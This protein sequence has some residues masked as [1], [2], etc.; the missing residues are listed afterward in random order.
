MTL[1]EAIIKAGNVRNSI[2]NHSRLIN[3][4]CHRAIDV[5][6]VLVAENDYDVIVHLSSTP[7][8]QTTISVEEFLSL[9]IC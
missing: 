5:Q 1:N 6:A 7:Q 9:A 8:G 4:I 2:V 3:N